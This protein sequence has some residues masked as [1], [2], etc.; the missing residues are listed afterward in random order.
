MREGFFYLTCKS[1]NVQM[2]EYADVQ[3]ILMTFPKIDID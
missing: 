3:M 1:V 2:C